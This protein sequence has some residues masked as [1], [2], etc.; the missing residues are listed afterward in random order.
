[1]LVIYSALIF[2]IL[3]VILSALRTRLVFELSGTSLLLFGTP[4]PGIIFYS[5]LV[6][7]GTVIHELSHWLIAEILQVRTGEIVILPELA[8]E[9]KEER[10]GSVQTERTDPLRGFLIGIAPFLTGLLILVTLGRLFSIGWFE[11]WAWWQLTLIVYGI[12]VMGDSMLISRS[13][14]RTWPII[15]V[16]IILIFIVLVRMRITPS[17]TIYDL[18]S[19]ILTSLNLILGVTAAANLVMI[20]GSYGTRR[21]VESLTKKR[22]M[23]KKGRSL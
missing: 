15:I 5:I 22:I 8:S 1:M 9:G 14:R 16:F 7:P 4:R 17:S 11:H 6:L 2:V 23:Q 10:L 21:L 12:V 20:G 3:I 13:D 18:S 19:T